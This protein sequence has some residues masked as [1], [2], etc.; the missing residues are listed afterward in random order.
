[1]KTTNATIFSLQRQLKNSITVYPSVKAI[2][3]ISLPLLFHKK[4]WRVRPWQALYN[5]CEQGRSLP[6]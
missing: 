3:T 4:S 1:M 6:V 2:I 5:I